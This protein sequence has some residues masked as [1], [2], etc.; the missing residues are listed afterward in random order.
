MKTSLAV[1]CLSW[2]AL[3]IAKY[4]PILTP[5]C[6]GYKIIYY[7]YSEDMHP[8]ILRYHGY[9]EG[10]VTMVAEDRYM[11]AYPPSRCGISDLITAL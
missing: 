2:L 10:Y 5:I 6:I 7:T 4:I 9:S 11:G 8:Y 3:N 1:Y